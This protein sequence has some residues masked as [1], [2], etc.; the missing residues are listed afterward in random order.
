MSKAKIKSIENRDTDL[1]NF[2]VVDD[3]VS[4]MYIILLF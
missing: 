1:N 3:K 2:F 4:K